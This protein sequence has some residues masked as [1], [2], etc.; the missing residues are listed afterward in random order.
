MPNKLPSNAT[1]QDYRRDYEEWR[2]AVLQEF[3]DEFNQALA[4]DE[5]RIA[6]IQ[7]EIDRKKMHIRLIEEELAKRKAQA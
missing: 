3:L 1:E 2:T 6:I 5:K 7:K 4:L